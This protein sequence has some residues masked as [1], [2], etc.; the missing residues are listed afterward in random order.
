MHSSPNY[1][2]MWLCLGCLAWCGHET[3]P[4]IVSGMCSNSWHDSDG[5][6]LRHIL[7][8]GNPTIRESKE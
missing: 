6:G 7:S 3:A 4:Q 2:E 1:Q 5:Y 8:N